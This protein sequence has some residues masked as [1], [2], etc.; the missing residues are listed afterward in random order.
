MRRIATGVVVAST[1][2]AAA[3]VAV[4]QLTSGVPDAQPRSGVQANLFAPGWTAEAVARGSQALENPQGFFTDYGFITDHSVQADGLDTKSE[5]DQNT[6]LVTRSNPGGPTA[7]F[8]YGTH[9]LVQGHEVFGTS[10]KHAYLTRINLDVPQTSAHRITLLNRIDTTG[11]QST[12]LSSVDGSTYDPFT[13]QLLFTEEAG[14]QGGVAAQ[15][16]RWSSTTPP[17]L[18]GLDGSLGRAGYEG[19]QLDNLG[20]V[21]LVED[22]GGSG[23][24]DNGSSTKVKQPNSFV[25]RFVPADPGDLTAGRLQALQVSVDGTPITFHSTPAGA[26]DDALGSAIKALHSGDVL[27]AR[28]VTVHDTATDGTAPF[29]AN[30]LAKAA[31]A[32]PLKRPENGK[33]VPQTGFRSFVFDETGDTDK[34]AGTYVSPVDGARADERGSWGAIL[35]LDMP[36]AGADT[37]TVR[38][39]V[40]GDAVHAAFDNL[41]FLN[42]STLLAAEDRGDNLHNQLDALDS[43]W[44]FDLRKGVDEIGADAKRVEAQ[45]RDAEAFADVQKKEATPPVADHNDGDNEVTGIHVFDGAITVGGIIGINDPAKQPGTRIFVTQ[46]HGENITFE[47]TPPAAP[48]SP[49]APNGPAGNP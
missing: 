2:L 3:A 17:A 15:K 6:Y 45:G 12:G 42:R 41:T 4:A 24:K 7:G 1:G 20:N 11:A 32:T 26:R 37:G 40:T 38:T 5:P 21:M 43:L 25:Y 39:I 49:N 16:L 23:V 28:W 9:F 22:T 10:P 27:Q 36:E 35:R 31:S 48:A 44:A 8:D 33:F 34:T 47:L 30:A 14:S 19:V 13:G 29:D 18:Q 46:Q